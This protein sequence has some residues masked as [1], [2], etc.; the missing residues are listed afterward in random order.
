MLSFDAW[1]AKLA[2]FY[3]FKELQYLGI[4]GVEVK[5]N[6]GIITNMSHPPEIGRLPYKKILSIIDSIFSQNI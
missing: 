2:Q 3:L 5:A 6:L 4:L 1:L